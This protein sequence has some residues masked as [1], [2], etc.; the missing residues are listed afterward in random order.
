M[1]LKKINNNT[2][3]FLGN[4]F[5]YTDNEKNLLINTAKLSPRKTSRICLHKNPN[6]VTQNMI[7]CILPFQEFP[8]HKHPIG[9]SESYTVIEG[10]LNVDILDSK[11]ILLKTLILDSFSGPYLHIGGTIH[12]PYT[13]ESFCIYQEV[14]HGKFSKEDDV[15]FV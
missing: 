3:Q 13:K 10:I 7:I 11:K 8:A 4:N 5:I 6:E 9:K 14:Y 1:I 15:I 12:R 2:F